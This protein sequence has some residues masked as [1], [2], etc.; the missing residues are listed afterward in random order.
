MTMKA[1]AVLDRKAAA[2]RAKRRESRASRLKNRIS[3][4][5]NLG[6]ISPAALASWMRDWPWLVEFD[7][8]DEVT[9]PAKLTPAQWNPWMNYSFLPATAKKYGCGIKLK[10]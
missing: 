1:V 5:S 10:N 3:R 8:L 7:G 2:E 9:D 4:R 6:N